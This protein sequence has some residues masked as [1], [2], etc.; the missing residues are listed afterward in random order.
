MQHFVA[1]L[2]ASRA[3]TSLPLLL[4]NYGA[5]LLQ[6]ELVRRQRANPAYSL[7]AFA[8]DLDLNPGTLSAVLKG[9]RPLTR[10]AAETL[11]A[12]LRLSPKGKRRLL[13]S[14]KGHAF[15]KLKAST[16]PEDAL[17]VD[18]RHFH[19]L[20]EWEH[21]AVLTL[22]GT[23]E[24]RVDAAW[25]A[26]RLG[27]PRTRADLVLK[28]LRAAGF[29]KREESGRDV[30]AAPAFKTSEDVASEALHKAHLE[31]LELAR[32]KLPLVSVDRRDYSSRTI[33]V[34]TKNLPKAK[35][36]IRR[37]RAELEELLDDGRADEVYQLCV[38][39]F[40]LTV[41]SN[42]GDKHEND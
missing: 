24:A 13:E 3:P 15:F 37:F 27:I 25:I 12:N 2:L 19:I 20:S 41:L 11:A 14:L 29:I 31:E 7:R 9:R 42:D 30:V 18:E 40:P 33:A 5:E 4:V 8:R 28:R 23:R 17:E 21:A 10:S 6:E 16:P 26:E 34:A 36:L 39:L 38:Q 32:R 35:T 22:L 1:N